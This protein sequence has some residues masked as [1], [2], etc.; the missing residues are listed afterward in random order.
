MGYAG[1]LYDGDDYYDDGEYPVTGLDFLGFP[2]HGCIDAEEYA[3]ADEDEDVCV[4]HVCSPLCS[5][6]VGWL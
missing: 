5:V 2:V 6:G 3:E 4:Y 1:S